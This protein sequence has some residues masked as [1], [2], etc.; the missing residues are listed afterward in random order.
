MK[1]SR[2][3]PAKKMVFFILC[4]FSFLDSHSNF[5]EANENPI[6]NFEKI[7]YSII[8]FP[9]KESDNIYAISN[10]RKLSK[11]EKNWNNIQIPEVAEME[12][13]TDSLESEGGKLIQIIATPEIGYLFNHWTLNGVFLSSAIEYEFQMPFEDA[14]IIGYFDKIEP[15]TI[16]VTSPVVNSSFTEG[17][18]IDISADV[19]SDKGQIIKVEFFVDGNLLVSFNNPPYLFT[20][21]NA[22]LGEHNIVVK[23]VDNSGQTSTS[24]AR[25]FA[26]FEKPNVAPTATI[27]APAANAQF[28][29]GSSVTITANAADSD[30]TI[31]KVEF[32]NGSTLLGTDTASPYSV[33]TAT[34]PLGSVSLTAKATDDKGTATVSAP[35]SI[36]VVEKPNVAP[37]ATI[38]APAAN[39]QF[40]QG[41]SVTITANA[42]D[43]DGTITKV[44]FYNGS[45]L[46][47]TD[48]ASPYSVATATLPLGSVSLT[49][50]A[51]D[52]KGTATVSA[53]VSISVVEKPNVAPTATIT[54]PAAN[55]Q[56]TQGS[57]VTI[58][59]NAAD[60]DGTITKVE[61]YNGSTLLGTDTA[62]PYSVAT[63]TLPLG[64]V[65]L[66]AKA[67]DDKGT[68]TVSAAVSISVVQQSFKV[69]SSPT[70]GGK[71]LIT[72]FTKDTNVEITSPL[73]SSTLVKGS[74]ISIMG[75]ASSLVSE[76]QT[77]EYFVDD[78][79]IGS[80]SAFP[81]EFKWLNVGEGVYQIKIKAYFKN[82][83]SKFSEI[84]KIIVK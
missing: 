74:T 56:F 12:T 60:S 19:I 24:T 36:N 73:N 2:K 80:S 39:A 31:T 66:T 43:S 30:G 10:Q 16:N 21:V 83:D 47:G 42:A 61:F 78:V 49:A 14:S 68:A 53:A 7:N 28:T 70:E 1:A 34:L 51:T 65:S 26:V 6:Y 27:T 64:S 57:S 50:K 45:T 72:Q 82:G 37:T 62:S 17:E 13:L 46:L 79:L 25:K 52:D 40:T 41:S 9:F 44:E 67:T 58:T 35:V 38:T 22:T 5:L 20:W 55:A 29:Q 4:F 59:A 75:T 11:I 48:T 32:Y 71:T 76:V 63:A 15:A 54:A 69:I 84:T 77:V 18:K 33:A 3:V 8:K 81:Y 23:A